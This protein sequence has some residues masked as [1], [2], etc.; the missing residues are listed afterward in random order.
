M[1]KQQLTKD[2]I[3]IFGT[4]ANF[5]KWL[6]YKNYDQSAYHFNKPDFKVPEY[7]IKFIECINIIERINKK[8]SVSV[9]ISVNDN[10]EAL[11]VDFNVIKEAGEY[12]EKI[13]NFS[14]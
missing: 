10:K 3:T 13:K 9:N 11:N 1:K 6:G 4:V 12:M 5:Y 7:M 2:I 14:K 8:Y